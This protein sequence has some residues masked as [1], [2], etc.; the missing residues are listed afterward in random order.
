MAKIRYDMVKFHNEAEARRAMVG[1]ALKRDSVSSYLSRALYALANPL[2]TCGLLI[3]KVHAFQPQSFIRRERVGN[4][5][6]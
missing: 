2:K 5:Y 1:T 6:E 3:L 4:N